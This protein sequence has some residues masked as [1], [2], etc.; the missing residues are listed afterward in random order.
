M[1][2]LLHQFKNQLAKKKIIV[3]QPYGT[4]MKAEGSKPCDP[5]GRSLDVD[6]Y[7]A[8]A[9]NLAQDHTVIFLGQKEFEHPADNFTVKVSQLN[10]DIRLFIAL[11]EQADYFIGVDSMGQHIAHSFSIPGSVIMGS[12]RESN[13]SYPDHFNIIR[14]PNT[15]P[16]YVPIRFPLMEVEYIDRLNDDILNFSGDQLAKVIDNIRSHI[17]Q[18]NEVIL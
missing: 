9:R 8:I 12:T 17:K 4:G 14:K 5:G 2:G 10:P 13:V 18:A 11:I 1:E 7:L 16:L 6:Q 15:N 3:F